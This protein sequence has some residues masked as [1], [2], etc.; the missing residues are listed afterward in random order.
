[1]SEEMRNSLLALFVLTG[2]VAWALRSFV[3]PFLSGR[4]E[5]WARS[6]RDD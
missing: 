3:A 6:V 4:L 5:E 2:L 1:M